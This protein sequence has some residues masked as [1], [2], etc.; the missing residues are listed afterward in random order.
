MHMIGLLPDSD[1]VNIR[2]RILGTILIPD[3][4]WTLNT[5]YMFLI[6]ILTADTDTLLTLGHIT[7]MD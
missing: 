6:L 1:I 5:E 3:M 7:Y 4:I 2:Y